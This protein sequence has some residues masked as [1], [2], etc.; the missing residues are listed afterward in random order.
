MR[1]I[2]N[3]SE[4]ERLRARL[5][6]SLGRERSLRGCRTRAL[7]SGIPHSPREAAGFARVSCACRG[8]RRYA[9]PSHALHHRPVSRTAA[10]A[11]SE[12]RPSFTG[13]AVEPTSAGYAPGKLPRY[14]FCSCRAIS[15]GVSV[16]SGTISLTGT[17]HPNRILTGSRL[18]RRR[19]H[20]PKGLVDRSE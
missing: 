18:N 4:Y 11:I 19:L 17:A 2:A 16:R 5:L 9:R 15:G 7:S 8:T 1:P 3:E 13:S 10:L 20:L 12:L 14:C 6:F